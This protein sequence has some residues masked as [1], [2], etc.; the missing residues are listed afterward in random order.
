MQASLV[1]HF[2]SGSIHLYGGGGGRIVSVVDRDD[3]GVGAIAMQS[4]PDQQV[5][6]L[7]QREVHVLQHHPAYDDEAMSEKEDED[8]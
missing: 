7:M 6:D 5:V 4:T 1:M 8:E 2:S 3:D